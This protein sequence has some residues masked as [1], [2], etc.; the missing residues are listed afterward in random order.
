MGRALRPRPGRHLRSP[1][2]GRPGYR[3]DAGTAVDQQRSQLAGSKPTASLSAWEAY[4]RG[5][6]HIYQY[7]PDDSVKALEFLQKAIQ[8]DPDFASAYGGVAFT[9]YVYLLMDLSDDREAD[10]ER[11][12]QSGLTAVELDDNDPFAHAGLGRIRIIRA[13]HEQAIASFER[14][15]DLNPSYALAFYGKAHAL[16]HCGHADQA[17]IAH[18]EAIRLSPSDPLMWTFLAS[19]AIALFLLDRFD[20]ALEFAPCPAIPD[21]RDLGLYGRAGHPRVPAA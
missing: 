15:L 20:E 18:D 19:K 13:E 9:M 3:D 7:K 10:L 4:Q 12:L 1:G 21:I 16:W 8:L 6:W 5:L 17:V 14:A 11:G 2:R